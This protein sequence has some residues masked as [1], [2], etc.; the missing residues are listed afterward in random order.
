[1]TQTPWQF[2]HI[3]KKYQHSIEK[4]LEH[5]RKEIVE[6]EVET[7]PGKKMLEAVDVYHTAETFIRQYCELHHLDF[8]VIKLQVIMK[9]KSRGYY[10]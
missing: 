10:D 2:P 5:I 7:D 6:F 4:C 3:S 8:E 1:M 9:N